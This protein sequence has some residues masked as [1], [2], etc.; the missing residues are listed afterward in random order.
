[1]LQPCKASNVS[2]I[3]YSKRRLANGRTSQHSYCFSLCV[4]CSTLCPTPPSVWDILPLTSRLGD[5]IAFCSDISSLARGGAQNASWFFYQEKTLRL[6]DRLSDGI[7][8]AIC[9]FRP[10]KKCQPGKLSILSEKLIKC[11]ADVFRRIVIASLSAAQSQLTF[12]LFK[13]NEYTD[14]TLSMGK[15][16]V[17]GEDWPPALSSYARKWSR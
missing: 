4:L 14:S 2:Y 15:W 8:E 11:G 12:A 16:D 10:G 1:M 6:N 13:S 5:W 3:Y 7:R 9:N 17:E